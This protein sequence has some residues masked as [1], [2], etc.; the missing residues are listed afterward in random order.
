MR[1]VGNNLK[2]LELSEEKAL[3]REETYEEQIRQLDTRLKEVELYQIYIN[4]TEKYIINKFT[5][6][7][8]SKCHYFFMFL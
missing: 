7:N 3:E 2:S 4:I 1:V 5:T 8:K 6:I